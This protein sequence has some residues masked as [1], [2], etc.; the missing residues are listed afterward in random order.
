M[1][2]QRDGWMDTEIKEGTKLKPNSC[3]L[4]LKA[5]VHPHKCFI[6]VIEVTHTRALNI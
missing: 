2:G 4:G 6:L 1:D 5:K 3:L